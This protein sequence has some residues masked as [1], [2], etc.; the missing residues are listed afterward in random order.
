MDRKINWTQEIAVGAFMAACL[1]SV[2]AGLVL[3]FVKDDATWLW[4]CAPVILF[5]S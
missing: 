4:L 5:L 2:V 1:G 3:T